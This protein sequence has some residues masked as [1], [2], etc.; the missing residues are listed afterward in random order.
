MLVFYPMSRCTLTELRRHALPVSTNEQMHDQ[1]MDN[2][3]HVLVAIVRTVRLGGDEP[4]ST[5]MFGNL[6]VKALNVALYIHP[7]FRD[8]SVSVSASLMA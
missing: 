3:H 5:A 7:M 6:S 4:Y 2:C 1:Q 8:S